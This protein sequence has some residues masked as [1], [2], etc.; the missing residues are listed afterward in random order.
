M[1][2]NG[3]VGRLSWRRTEPFGIEL[4]G[5]L[6]GPLDGAE[7]DAL[8]ALFA[9]GWLLVAHGQRL[10]NDEH[11]RLAG[12]LG[13]LASPNDSVTM[14]SVKPA[15][16]GAQRGTLEDIELPWHVDGPAMPKP[17]P[18]LS[19]HAVEVVDDQTSTFFASG[20]LAYAALPEQLRQRVGGLRAVHAMPAVPS[21]HNTPADFEGLQADWPMGVHDLVKAHPVTGVPFLFVG[22]QATI[23]IEG[24]DQGEGEA[25]LQE[26][27]RYYYRPEAVYEHRWRNGDLVIWDNLVVNHRRSDLVG[28]TTR[29]LQRVQLAEQTFAEA[30]PHFVPQGDYLK[31]LF[32]SYRQ[33]EAEASTG[34]GGR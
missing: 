28:V 22:Y 5:D 7:R 34:S 24:M 19:L 12:Y 15:A 6:S 31:K 20:A 13:P 25:L 1:Q 23:G 10:D 8:E 9:E 2:Q 11:R 17:Y 4:S 18:A 16:A 29:S 30:F 26:L 33:A 27:F 14:I 3:T 21:R 32:G